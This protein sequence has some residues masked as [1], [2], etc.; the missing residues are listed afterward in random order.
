LYSDDAIEGDAANE[1]PLSFVPTDGDWQMSIPCFAEDLVWVQRSLKA[2]STRITARALGAA[3][4]DEGADDEG[5]ASRNGRSP[6]AVDR[7]AFF[8]H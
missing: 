6:A 3:V 8:R 5:N 2:A 1:S 7:D 4:P